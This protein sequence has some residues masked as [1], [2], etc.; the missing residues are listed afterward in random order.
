MKIFRLDALLPLPRSRCVRGAHVVHA[1]ARFLL[2][3]FVAGMSGL[4]AAQANISVNFDIVP[5]AAGAGVPRQIAVSLFWPSGCLPRGASVIGT[6]IARK[7]TFTIRLDGNLQDVQ[8]CGDLIVTYRTTVSFTPD[9]EGDLR[10]LV[11]MDDGVY[12]GETTL[13]TR[14]ANSNR[15][16]YDLTGMWYDPTTFGSGM[17]FVHGFT[18]SDTVFGTWYV[19]DGQGAPRW[20][21]IQGVQW[22]AGGLQA[23]GQLYWTNASSVVCL[24]PFTGC[25]VA[26]SSVTSIAQVSIVMQGPNSARIIALNPQGVLV[27]NLIRSI[28]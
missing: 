1:C 3:I 26:F 28:F 24:P 23:V 11:V 13:H 5:V 27:T 17:T 15:A 6:E 4:A 18:G 16:Q 14:A 12:V 9:N 2:M 10:A 25:P 7:R 20:Y 19:Y 8:R 22:I 21:T